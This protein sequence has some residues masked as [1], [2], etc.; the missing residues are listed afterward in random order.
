MLAT[1]LV[2]LGGGI[3]SALRHGVNVAAGRWLGTTY[4]WH[5]LTV[6]IVGSFAMGLIVG[7]LAMRADGSG[8]QSLRLFLATGICGGFTTFSAYSLDLVL[9]WERGEPTA[10]ILY[11]AGSVALSIIGLLGGLILM[12]SM[13]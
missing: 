10:A 4:P 9:M 8:S 2:F 11:G 1:L 5:T 3:G 12:R 6:N 7:W 13:S